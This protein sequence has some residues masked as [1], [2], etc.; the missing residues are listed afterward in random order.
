MK[1]TNSKTHKQNVFN[2]KFIGYFYSDH[3]I[4]VKNKRGATKLHIALKL[5][6]YSYTPD[7]K[8]FKLKHF[9]L[10][11]HYLYMHLF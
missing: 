1:C 6:K 11:K 10:I 5:H 7:I 9:Y 4:Y 2:S 3:I 8:L